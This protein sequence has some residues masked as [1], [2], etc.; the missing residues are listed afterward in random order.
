MPE[1]GCAPP[2]LKVAPKKVA[3]G[4]KFRFGAPNPISVI[5][6]LR[7]SASRAS[8]SIDGTGKIRGMKEEGCHTFVS[9]I[10]NILRN[11][12]SISTLESYLGP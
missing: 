1:L 3:K 7:A 8:E 11:M 12:Y 9:S 5:Q 2:S 6:F 10:W 4:L